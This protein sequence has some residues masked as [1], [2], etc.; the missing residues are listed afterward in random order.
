MQDLI[1]LL[2]KLG[3]AGMKS[4][5]TE[6]TN[7]GNVGSTSASAG[8]GGT[9]TILELLKKLLTAE[10]EYK[11]SR[12]LYYRL[13]LARFPGIKLLSDTVQA[14][15]SQNIDIEKVIDNHENLSLIH[16]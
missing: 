7:L 12:S 16:I 14:K 2:D 11:K 3:L 8:T 15:L 13:Q 5:L 6:I 4:Q 1:L 9:S 10:C